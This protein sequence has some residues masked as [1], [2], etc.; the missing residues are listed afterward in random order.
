MADRRVTLSRKDPDGDISALCN[1]GELW[2]P[3]LKANV[4][5]DIE[6]GVHT[7][8]VLSAGNRVRVHV[9]RGVTGKYLRTSPDLISHNNLDDLPDC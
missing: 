4:I 2:S 8:Y 1:P 7:Y 9:L 6:S 5:T 3:R